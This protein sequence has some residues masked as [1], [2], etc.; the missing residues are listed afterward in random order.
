M[1]RAGES[2]KNNMRGIRFSLLFSRFFFVPQL[3]V[4]GPNR[5]SMV[6]FSDQVTSENSI[7]LSPQ[8]LYAKPSDS[9]VCV[10]T[11][12]V[13]DM[14]RLDRSQ[15]KKEWIRNACD[16]DFSCCWREEERETSLL[17][18]KERKKEGDCETEFRKSDCRPDNI[19]L[20]ESADSRISTSSDKF[21]E[22][23]NRGTGYE[24]CRDSKW[25]S[26]WGPEDKEKEMRTEK[27]VDAEK[28]DSHVEK[29]FFIASFHPLFGSDS[30]DKWRPRHRQDV[31]SVGSSVIRAAPGFG[32]ERLSTEDSNVGFAR[33]RGRSDSVLGL[34]F[35]R[36]SVADPIG[37][38]PGNKL[39]FRYPR[40][41]LLDIFR[42]QK[43]VI[44]ATLERFVEVPP[45]TESSFV[46]PLAFVIPD[47]EEEVI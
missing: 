22:V 10:S 39:V 1:D 24:N 9:K 3:I 8:W 25:S 40:G 16:I 20:R 47:A 29:Q 26:R 30:R 12:L 27:K 33:G 19:L 32:L 17:G 37:A 34:Q 44:D 46:T 21:H 18:R 28:E 2:E 36:S 5:S 14:W 42:K 13:K 4:D 35:G 11:V 38:T 45:I 31:Y 23:P 43:T 41:K 6:D 7:P 15:D